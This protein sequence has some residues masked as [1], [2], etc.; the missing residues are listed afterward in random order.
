[1]KKS[2]EINKVSKRKNTTHL[3]EAKAEASMDFNPMAN[4]SSYELAGFLDSQIQRLGD[5]V[6]RNEL[7]FNEVSYLLERKLK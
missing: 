2:N 4:F 5:A 1:M 7:Y 6:N 3:I